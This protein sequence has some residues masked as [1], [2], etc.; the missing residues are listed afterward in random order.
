MGPRASPSPRPSAA[1]TGG[2]VVVDVDDDEYEPAM[3]GPMDIDIE[4]DEG[5]GD[6][7]DSDVPD[8]TASSSSSRPPSPSSTAATGSSLGPRP[9]PTTTATGQQQSPGPAMGGGMGG[10]PGSGAGSVPPKDRSGSL[11][12]PEGLVAGMGPAG[13]VSTEAG[14]RASSAG[15]ASSTTSGLGGFV[16]GP[17]T[18]RPT[19]TGALGAG[20][21]GSP[22]ARVVVPMG[23]SPAVSTMQGPKSVLIEAK[24]ATKTVLMG[25]VLPFE[26]S[27]QTPVG[28]AVHAALLMALRDLGPSLKI[29]VNINLTCLNTRCLDIP[30]HNAMEQLV[31]AGAVA[32]VGDICSAASVAAAGVAGTKQVP[33]ISPASSSPQLTGMSFFYRTVP[34]DRYQG[35]AAAALVLKKGIKRVGMVYEDVSYGYGLAFNF[36][37]SFTRDGGAVSPVEVFKKFQG[38]PAAAVAKMVEARASKADPIQAVVI[39]TSNITYFTEFLRAA[40]AAKLDL[41]I[42]GGD[43]IASPTTTDLLRDSPGLLKNVHITAFAQGSPAF[44]KKFAEVNPGLEYDGNA[45]QGYDAMHALL[46]AYMDAPAP[47]E[48]QDIASQITKQ[49]FKGVSGPIAFDSKGDLIPHDGVYITITFDPKTGQMVFGDSINLPDF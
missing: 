29:P 8:V 28:K 44:Q 37:A 15:N 39:S 23:A 2:L 3:P 42:L 5:E 17:T 6:E 13:S 46:R 19:G 26:G 12:G 43:A 35:A 1:V 38:D 10:K 24:G 47:K 45:A 18:P 25:C 30:A 9:L 16:L 7:E 11:L 40:A 21:A 49:K 20:A 14:P 41:P 4:V 34:S 27:D 31:K 33:L 32:V 48:P 22:G 36:I